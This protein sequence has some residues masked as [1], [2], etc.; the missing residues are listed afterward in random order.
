M[1]IEK[2]AEQFILIGEAGR[3][4]FY[5]VVNNEKRVLENPVKVTG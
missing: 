4:K 2:V 1:K 3:L 5:K